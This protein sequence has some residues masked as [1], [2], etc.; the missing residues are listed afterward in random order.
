[1]ALADLVVLTN[2]GRIEQQG[3]PRRL[4][5]AS[6]RFVARFMGGHNVVGRRPP[7]R[8][9]L[10][11]DPPR[12]RRRPAPAFARHRISGP[13]VP[14]R[15]HHHDGGRNTYAMVP[16]PVF[17]R[18][19]LEP[20]AVVSIDWDGDAAHLLSLEAVPGIGCPKVDLT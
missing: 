14:R 10:G 3:S 8:H 13:H 6:A 18:D 19:P 15:G 5:R 20:G 1:M 2:G 17:D 16:G 9:P 7:D 11:P 4:Q 12:A